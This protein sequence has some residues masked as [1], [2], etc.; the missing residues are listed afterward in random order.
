MHILEKDISRIS[1]AE[2]LSNRVLFN[3]LGQ[4]GLNSLV[5]F[6]DTKSEGSL[7]FTPRQE[8]SIG[9][10]D[11][12]NPKMF[13]DLGDM[14]VIIKFIDPDDIVNPP[15]NE[16]RAPEQYIADVL[17]ITQEVRETE[18][19]TPDILGIAKIDGQHAIIS[20]FDPNIE[21]FHDLL[22][23]PGNPDRAEIRHA[24]GCAATSI[25]G[26]HSKGIVHGDFDSQNTAHDRVTNQ[27]RTIDLASAYY[28]SSD[29]SRIFDLRGYS[30]TLN[31]QDPD[32]RVSHVWVSDAREEFLDPYIEAVKQGEVAV[33]SSTREYIKQLKDLWLMIPYFFRRD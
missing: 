19:P 28:E 22:R 6:N 9:R 11:G 18:A 32:G 27:A 33:P 15:I 23:N 7:S 30:S 26:L 10:D 1:H 17:R 25:I 8:Y 24:L 2:K 13:G 14:P 5:L 16:G 3:A 21:S 20:E 31:L 12:F 29:N 4:M